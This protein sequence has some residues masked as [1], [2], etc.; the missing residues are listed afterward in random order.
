MAGQT[1]KSQ[2]RN[3]QIDETEIGKLETQDY[4]LRVHRA[5]LLM[6]L[7]FVCQSYRLVVS[8]TPA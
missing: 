6:D 7:I 3:N 1:A 5:K 2:P 4:W 8:V